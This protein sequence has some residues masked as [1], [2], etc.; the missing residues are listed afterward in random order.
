MGFECFDEVR[1]GFK[2]GP[3]HLAF[4]PP[5]QAVL[6]PKHGWDMSLSLSIASVSSY[7]AAVNNGAQDPFRYTCDRPSQPPLMDDMW[8]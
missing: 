5:P 6:Y 7:G 2:F 4:Y 1:R 3:N 8:I